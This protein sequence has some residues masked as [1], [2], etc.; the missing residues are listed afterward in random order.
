MLLF[1]CLGCA[2][3]FGYLVCMKVLHKIG[4]IR[5]HCDMKDNIL[6][7]ALSLLC[8]VYMKF[9]MLSVAKLGWKRCIGWKQ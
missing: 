3:V 8:L 1:G 9:F 6:N 5:S 2:C 4:F 7:F